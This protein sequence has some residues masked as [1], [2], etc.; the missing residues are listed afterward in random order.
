MNARCIRCRVSLHHPQFEYCTVP[1]CPF[2]HG[3]A[4]TA[5]AAIAPRVSLPRA[6]EGEGRRDRRFSPE[7]LATD[8]PAPNHP[9][10]AA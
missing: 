8:Y 3:A 4:L 5:E 7:S 10:D 1:S 6:G 9:G 2:D